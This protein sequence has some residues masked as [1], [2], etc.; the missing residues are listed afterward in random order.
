MFL[1]VTWKV[2]VTLP[3]ALTLVWSRPWAL[4]MIIGSS[5]NKPEPSLK[6]PK[7]SRHLLCSMGWNILIVF[8]T[9]PG[10]IGTCVQPYAFTYSSP[11]ASTP[12]Q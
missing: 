7:N 4:A 2:T 11:S 9:M 3:P 6:L 12:V 5:M 8:W 10:W 1:W